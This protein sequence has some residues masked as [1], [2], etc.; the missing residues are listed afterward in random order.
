M[1][2]DTKLLATLRSN[3]LNRSL[4]S[5]M[6]KE[7][8]GYRPREFEWGWSMTCSMPELKAHIEMLHREIEDAIDY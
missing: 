8:R 5:D 1:V 4:Y 7:A 2:S 3:F 6:H